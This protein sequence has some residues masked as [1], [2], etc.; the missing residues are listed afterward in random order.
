MELADW[1]QR[2]EQQ[3]PIKWDLGLAR[4]GEVG[5]R[6]G[7]L[8]PAPLTFL[9]AGTNG[10][11]STCEYITQLC[12][13]QHLKVGKSTSPHL[14]RFNE[15][16]EIDG[17]PAS[18]ALICGA[19]ETIDQARAEISLTYFEYGTL[20]ALVIFKQLAVDVAVL[21]IGL[22]GRLDA[23]NI[24]DPDVSVITRIALDHQSWLGD[25][26]EL[27]GA[28]KAGILRAGIPCVLVDRAPPVSILEQAKALQ[29]PLYALGIDF[30]HT[31]GSLWMT[32]EGEH[33]AHAGLPALN[34]PADSLV[35]ACQAVACAG[36]AVSHPDIQLAAE[37]GQVPG[38]FQQLAWPRRTIL[39]VAHNP[40]AAA[41]LRD[42]LQARL[43][44]LPQVGRC[45]AVVG[46]YADKDYA[47][48]LD[49]LAP[50]VSHFYC[51]DMDESRAASATLLAE[52]LTNLG[53]SVVSSYA[54]VA[55][56]Y[57]AAVQQCADEDYILVFGSFPV[58]A[59]VLDVV[60]ERRPDEAAI[61][62]P[63]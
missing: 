47:G 52:H 56:A 17:E 31:E 57:R 34:L 15:R 61:Q 58:V 28:E 11:G 18:D 3:H 37:A 1:L 6:L 7:V 35:A 30:D 14:R 19:F 38:R 59:G 20:A 2:I 26:R 24:V 40:D 29:V 50:L 13:A 62:G 23:M 21:E 53:G 16:I 27:I 22:G 10:K 12:R 51:T 39:D 45:H 54:K 63:E 42:K 36:L 46:M 25:T 33:L 5:R 44:Q 49:L 41:Y 4:V 55:Q 32:H 60:A 48:V 9:V 43:Q 8:T